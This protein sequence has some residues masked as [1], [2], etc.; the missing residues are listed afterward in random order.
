MFD[1]D[2]DIM[3]DIEKFE[4]YVKRD[5]IIHFYLELTKCKTLNDYE[6]LKEKYATRAREICMEYKRI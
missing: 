2:I 1:I 4:G 6:E 5:S 3:D